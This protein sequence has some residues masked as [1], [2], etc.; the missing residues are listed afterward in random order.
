MKKDLK[1]VERDLKDLI[2][3]YFYKK[4]KDFVF[5]EYEEDEMKKE[6]EDK[7]ENCIE[8]LIAELRYTENQIDGFLEDYEFY[9]EE[10][11][12]EYEFRIKNREY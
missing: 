8:E 10:N 11:M 12:R 2:E 1:P 7:V 6:L 5:N 9:R 4:T 3:D